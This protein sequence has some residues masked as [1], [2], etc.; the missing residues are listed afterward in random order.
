[1]EEIKEKEFETELF[2][3]MKQC[4]KGLCSNSLV[5]VA[6]YNPKLITN[7]AREQLTYVLDITLSHLYS[8][9]AE[10]GK[11]TVKGPHIDLEVTGISADSDHCALRS[12]SHHS[13]PKIEFCD[14]LISLIEAGEV[15]SVLRYPEYLLDWPLKGVSLYER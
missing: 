1:M 4:G 6:V 10:Y 5:N 9:S 14:G 12:G 15:V 11:V 8:Y 13:N 3:L 7:A 2:N